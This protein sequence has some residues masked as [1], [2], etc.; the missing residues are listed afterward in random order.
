MDKEEHPFIVGEHDSRS[1]SLSL[2]FDGL[3]EI[4][5]KH[6]EKRSTSFA[7]ESWK[8]CIGLI[9]KMLVKIICRNPDV[10]VSKA[11]PPGTDTIAAERAIIPLID[12]INQ[13]LRTEGDRRD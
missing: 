1:A 2:F 10:D 13:I 4:L 5:K 7:N 11:L 3:L 12:K 6:H 9:S 8:F